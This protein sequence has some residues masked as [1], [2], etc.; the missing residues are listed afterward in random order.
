MNDELKTLGQQAKLAA[1]QLIKLTTAHK[2]K[3]LALISE[4]IME[5]EPYILAAN[6]KDIE[7][8]ENIEGGK[9]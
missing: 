2:N 7:A 4:I 1:R 5:R 9:S 8:G 6:D 3:A